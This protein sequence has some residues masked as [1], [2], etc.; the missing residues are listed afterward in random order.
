MSETARCQGSWADMHHALHPACTVLGIPHERHD[1]VTADAPSPDVET[2]LAQKAA[3]L[4][5]VSALSYEEAHHLLH[6]AAAA[7]RGAALPEP[8][9]E[10]LAEAWD[11]GNARA[12]GYD[13]D[14]HL[15]REEWEGEDHGG[16][17]PYRQEAT[18]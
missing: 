3:E 17:N 5:R 11:K 13:Y 10:A 14:Y 2:V 7:L 8:S 6:M 4:A 1:V 16:P 9:G 15:D 12:L 18:P